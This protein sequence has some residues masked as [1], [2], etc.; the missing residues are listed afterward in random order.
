[1]RVIEEALSH[2]WHA[3]WRRQLDERLTFARTADLGAL[4]AL[5]V[6]AVALHRGSAA[7][8]G[9]ALAVGAPGGE[10]ITVTPGDTQVER[11]TGLVI[12]ARFRGTPPA[13]ATLV[14]NSATGKESQ[15]PMSRQLADPIFG[16][17]VPV[18]S[19]AGVYH[20]EYN[21]K[22]TRDYKITIFEYPAL[23]R[24]D[25]ELRY[26]SYTGLTN[27]TIRDTLRVSAVQGSHLTY[28]MQLNKPVARASWV[29]KDVSL[30]LVTQSNAVALLPEYLLTNNARFSLQL[31]DSE[32]RSNKFPTDFILQALSRGTSAFRLWRNCN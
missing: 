3:E 12:A 24:A 6:V 11:G 29:S 13:D 2:P 9:G 27:R 30:P 28:T 14:L 7:E 16:T 17:S 31:V 23:V 22:K 4:L 5:G 18:V 20:I 19:E 21:G 15:M 26:P 8:P 10:E 1:L 25:A 32:G